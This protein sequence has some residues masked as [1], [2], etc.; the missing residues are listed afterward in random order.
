MDAL[1]QMRSDWCLKVALLRH[2][3]RIEQAEADRKAARF[4]SVLGE[5]EFIRLTCK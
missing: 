1:R 2:E 4:D 3:D 5:R